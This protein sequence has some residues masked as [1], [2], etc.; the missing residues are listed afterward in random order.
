MATKLSPCEGKSGHRG[1]ALSDAA[2]PL[3][4]LGYAR[5]SR[6][7]FGPPGLQTSPPAT[8]VKSADL[9]QGALERAQITAPARQKKSVNFPKI[10][11]V[12]LAVHS[13]VDFVM[14]FS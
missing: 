7:P 9:V 13:A 3:D 8:E 14:N 10:V 6:I 5:D 4:C 2:C 12:N 11:H 1:F